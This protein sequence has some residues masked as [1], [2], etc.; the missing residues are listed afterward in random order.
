MRQ[1][2]EEANVI[3]GTVIKDQMNEYVSYTV[4]A[5]RLLKQKQVPHTISNLKTEKAERKQMEK[6]AARLRRI[7]R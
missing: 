4:I 3:F 6:K 5:T 7:L 1:R 2:A